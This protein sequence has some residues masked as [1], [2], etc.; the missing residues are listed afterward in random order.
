MRGRVAAP[1]SRALHMRHGTSP[2]N[3][4][5]TKKKKKKT[6]RHKHTNSAKN[7]PK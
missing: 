2:H 1:V 5:S 7:H 3:P 6:D 4:V